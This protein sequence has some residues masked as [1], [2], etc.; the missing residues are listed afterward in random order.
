M[1]FEIE[2]DRFEDGDYERFSVRLD[3]SV[4]ALEHMLRRPGFGVGPMTIG[5]ELE[6]HLVGEGGHPAPVNRAVLSAAVDERVTLEIN[7]YNIE[8]NTRA[9]PLAGRPFETMAA[10]LMEALAVTRAAAGEHGAGVVMIGI[11]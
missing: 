7:R 11:L 4:A 3:R 1:G 9:F 2:R 10:E 8:I 5:A 6:L